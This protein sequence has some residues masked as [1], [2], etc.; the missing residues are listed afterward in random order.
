MFVTMQ[1]LGMSI[2]MIK[3]KS[4]ECLKT[5]LTEKEES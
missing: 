3:W 5:L 2:N 1:G 4:L